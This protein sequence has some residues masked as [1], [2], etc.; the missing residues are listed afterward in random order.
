MRKV[1]SHQR[2][3]TR[4][5]RRMPQPWRRQP[6]RWRK[7]ALPIAKTMISHGPAMVATIV[8]GPPSVVAGSEARH[9]VARS[10]RAPAVQAPRGRD[11]QDRAEA[12]RRVA[13]LAVREVQ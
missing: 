5:R 3:D 10:R 1:V 6:W 11:R 4:P 7:F 2:P 8:L 13:Q 12:D 9:V